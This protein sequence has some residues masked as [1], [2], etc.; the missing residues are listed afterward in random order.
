MTRFA[1]LQ[2]VRLP[3]GVMT[4]ICDIE[5]RVTYVPNVKGGY[6][7]G[8]QAAQLSYEDCER[9]NA[10]LVGRFPQV[11]GDGYTFDHFL[12]FKYDA[13]CKLGDYHWDTDMCQIGNLFVNI[14]EDF[15]G[16]ELHFPHRCKLFSPRASQAIAWLNSRPGVKKL[17][18]GAKHGAL[19][20]LR[21]T[22][23][24]LFARILPF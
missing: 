24:V 3:A 23:I 5:S 19:K 2:V 21:G 14:N 15:N 20:V 6:Y 13:S 17:D 16:G 10:L 8:G 11:M 18:L 7:T 12:F 22:K 1:A 4:A 9:L